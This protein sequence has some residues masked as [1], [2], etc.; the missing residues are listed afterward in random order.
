[1]AKY[2]VSRKAH[3]NGD[4]EVHNIDANCPYL[5]FTLNQ[6]PLGEHATCDTAVAAARLIYETANGCYNCAT[7]CHVLGGVKAAGDDAQS[8]RD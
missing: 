2:C 3:S 5:P 4:H 6:V 1:M 7:G 8:V